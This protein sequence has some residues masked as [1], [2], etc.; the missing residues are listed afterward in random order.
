MPI[1]APSQ[2]DICNGALDRARAGNINDINENSLQALK[3]R[4][5]Y[6]KVISKL[7][8]THDWSFANQRI[9]L[10][11]AGTNDRPYEWLYAYLIPAN[12]AQPIRA[13]PDYTTA[14]ITLPLPIPGEPY[15]ETWALLDTY[16]IPY[17]VLDGI[18]YCN[19][20]N[21]WLDYTIADITGVLVTR[22]FADAVEVEL[23]YRVCV[24]LKGDAALKK[25]LAVEK[26]LMLQQAIAVDR[27]RQPQDWG[28]YISESIAARHNSNIALPIDGDI[29]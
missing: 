15:S 16:A 3:C 1:P 9:Q 29:L 23:A 13:L 12:C 7:L 25:D 14:G 4:L 18:L 2:I 20:E 10:A 27:N 21:A 5:H 17:E 6:P 22:A 19:A 24:S 26:E 8:E 28:N 11:E